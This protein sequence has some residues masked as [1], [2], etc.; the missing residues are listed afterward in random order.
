MDMEKIELVA[1]SHF[2][3]ARRKG[4]RIRRV[5]EKWIVRDL[6]LVVVNAGSIRIQADGVRITDEVHFMAA[7][8]QLH[9]QFRRDNAA[10]AIGG[11]ARDA[12]PHG[13]SM[14]P[15]VYSPQ[16]QRSGGPGVVP[17]TDQLTHQ[18]DFS[19]MLA[20]FHPLM[21]KP[22]IYERERLNR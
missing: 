3:H 11:I 16:A 5:L 12:D 7:M 14:R 17:Q 1:L 10:A 15:R 19:H 20:A 6:Y 21:R 18:H 13:F 2:G 8:R 22:R 9:A 4:E